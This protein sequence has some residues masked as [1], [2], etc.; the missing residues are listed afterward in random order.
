MPPPCSHAFKSRAL[1][2]EEDAAA[3]RWPR[4]V[5]GI[6]PSGGRWWR[7]KYRFGGKEKRISLGIYPDVGL[8]EARDKREAA[9]QQIAAGIDPSERRKAEQ[10]SAVD[11]T[12]NT[13]EV[14]AREWYQLVSPTWVEQHRNKIIRRLEREIFPFIGDKP[15]KQVSAQDLLSALRRIEARGFNETAHR[16]LQ[17]CGCVFRYAVA[18]GRADRDLT[19]DECR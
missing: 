12:E 1:S 14:I 5:R 15:M 8:K 6:C 19:R 7:L 4:T 10:Q 18:C 3:F 2:L 13:F 17:H 16:T 9:R 11:H